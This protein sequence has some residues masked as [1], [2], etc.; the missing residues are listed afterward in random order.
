LS[1]T[2]LRTNSTSVD[3]S[4]QFDKNNSLVK[5]I[6]DRRPRLTIGSNRL[7]HYR[8]V[9]GEPFGQLYGR[10]YVRDDQGRVIVGSSGLPNVTGTDTTL[11]GNVKPDWTGSFQSNISYE[12][13]SLSF[14]VDHRQGG[15]VGTLTN[16]II[17][18]GG[19]TK[20]TLKGRG[21]GIIFGDN[22][23]PEETAVNEDGSPNDVPTNAEAFWRTMGERSTP[24]GEVFIKDGSY[25]KLREV[26]LSYSFP[27]S[28]TE[29]L[30]VSSANVSVVGRNLM[31]LY[32]ASDRIDADV[33]T[34]TSTSDE[35]FESFPPPS[36]RS[37]GFNINMTY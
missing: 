37:F 26:I 14:Q 22:F 2:P 21:G 16:A 32:R 12:N 28:L 6:S 1:G 27:E 17:D 19:Y 30:P 18:G 8:V 15:S 24:V 10:A 35:G 13:F 11:I 34:G 3:L 20:R 36:T 7:T 9:E 31:F 25:T 4:V 33:L 29:S 23:F 5:E